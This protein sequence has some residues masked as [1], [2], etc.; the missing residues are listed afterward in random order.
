MNDPELVLCVPGPWS[1]APDLLRPITAANSGYVFL[2]RTLTHVGTQ[3]VFD[4]QVEDRDPRMASAFAKAGAHWVGADDLAR[5]DAHKTVAYL[6]ATG[7]SRGRAEE[8]MAAASVLLDAGG[9]AVKVETTGLAH[10]GDA[11][12]EFV[13]TRYLFSAHRALVV[14]VTGD[15]VYSCG[16][17]NLGYRDAV[18]NSSASSD[19]AELLRVFTYYL[20]TETPTIISGQTFSTAKGEPVYRVR[21]EPCM[22][23]DGDP[24]FTNP[25]GMWRL[26]EHG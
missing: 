19:A 15:E 21:A 2:G 10:S 7:G 22:Q 14:Y 13:R 18:V 9:F 4:V 11:W 5:I 20:F 17:H 8:A 1:A 26:S 12:R 16:M 23:H 25:Y 3:S 24:L 6:I